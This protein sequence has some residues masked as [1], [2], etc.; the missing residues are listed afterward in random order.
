MSKDI[1][2]QEYSSNYQAH[3][4]DLILHIQ[5]VE[6]NISITEEDQPDLFVIDDYYQNGTGNF[7]IALNNEEVIGTISLL[8]I[9]EDQ[10]ALRKMFVHKNYRGQTYKTASL[11]LHTALTWARKQQLHAIY[12]GTTPQFLAAHRFYEKNGFSSISPGELPERFP[13]LEV[14]KKFYKYVIN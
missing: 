11:L 13:V 4:L 14:D 3:V 9:G 7:W 8:D 5:Q 10:V 12:L 1:L 2:V 6:Y